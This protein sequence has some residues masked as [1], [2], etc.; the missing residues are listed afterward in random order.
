MGIVDDFLE[1]LKAQIARNDGV[2]SEAE[3]HVVK[4]VAKLN[5]SVDR[6]VIFKEVLK[7]VYQDGKLAEDESDVAAFARDFLKITEA[8][9]QSAIISLGLI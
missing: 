7:A 6:V 4:H 8:E 9:H 3:A 1:E 2:V 5:S